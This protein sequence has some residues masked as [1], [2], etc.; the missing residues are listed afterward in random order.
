LET[1]A[2]TRRCFFHLH[3]AGRRIEDAE[4]PL[5]LDADVAWVAAHATARALLTSEPD[6]Q[7]AWLASTFEVTNRR[8]EVLLEFPFVE[9][10]E[11]KVEPR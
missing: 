6:R 4:G 9:A 11:M 7:P 5:L 8:G 10:V 2:V 3:H 1:L